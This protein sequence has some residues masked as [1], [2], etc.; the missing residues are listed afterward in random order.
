MHK[1]PIMEQSI[2]EYFILHLDR[3]GSTYFAVC[4]AT[5]GLDK[6]YCWKA[7]KLEICSK[8]CGLRYFV[9][10]DISTISLE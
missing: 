10:D 1:L 6:E 7:L 4:T 2:M 5:C 8:K 9:L 3:K